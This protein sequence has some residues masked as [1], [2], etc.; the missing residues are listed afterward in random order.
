[1][2]VMLH[3]YIS[4]FFSRALIMLKDQMFYSFLICLSCRIG[5]LSEITTKPML[6][7]GKM[8]VV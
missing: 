5:N 4:T 3:V 1:M 6:K 2:I 7:D 8:R